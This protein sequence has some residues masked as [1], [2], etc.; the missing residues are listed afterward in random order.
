MWYLHTHCLGNDG[1]KLCT[2]PGKAQFLKYSQWSGVGICDVG[3]ECLEDVLQ[4]FF[5]LSEVTGKEEEVIVN[6]T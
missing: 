1:D 5:F 6:G 4:C 2:G 3:P